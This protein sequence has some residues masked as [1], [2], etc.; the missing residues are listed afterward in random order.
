MAATSV[1]LID[2]L[3]ALAGSGRFATVLCRLSRAR[4]TGL[5]Y[6]E[7]EE[8]GAVLSYRD[9]CPVFIEDLGGGTSLGDSLLEQGTLTPESYATVLEHALSELT[10]SEDAAFA[11]KAV[12]LGVL[13]QLDVDAELQRR[14]RGQMIQAIAWD[15]ARIELDEDPDALSGPEYPQQLGLL[16][17]MAVRTFF[18]EDR[19]AAFLG[20]HRELYLRLLRPRAEVA[21]DLGLDDAERALLE[22][23]DPPSSV[24]SAVDRLGTDLLEAQQLVAM[25]IISENVEHACRPWSAPIET[26]TR[27]RDR[28][29]STP[30]G[31]YVAHG[32]LTEEH[33]GPIV[34]PPPPQPAAPK[35]QVA[36]ADNAA[37]FEAPIATPVRSHADRVRGEQVRIESAHGAPPT[38]QT[39]NTRPPLPPGRV[40]SVR[41]RKPEARPRRLGAALKRLGRELDERRA[42]THQLDAPGN[43]PE[44]AAPARPAAGAA[45][46]PA[47]PVGS[48]QAD[49]ANAT[50]RTAV[51][52]LIRRKRALAGQ[53]ARSSGDVSGAQPKQSSAELMRSARDALRE[54]QYARAQELL[55]RACEAEPNNET[56]KM[57]RLWAGFR[58]GTLQEAEQVA[59]RTIVRDKINDDAIKPFASYAMGHLMLADKK[60]DAAEKFFKKAL[61]LDKNNRDAERH[62]RLIGARRKTGSSH[63]ANNKIFGIEIG[64]KS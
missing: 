8:G 22:A 4:F 53:Q 15:S 11:T 63:E 19:V 2:E 51:K 13:T 16:L 3:S 64:K 41:P 12:E 34:R 45:Y 57:Y 32:A 61:E 50:G 9:G 47:G 37:P 62:V 43:A 10:G 23:L 14:I 42:Q 40:A 7:R 49:G 25:L 5:L 54:Q 31:R 27:A 39:P 26:S 33:L 58:A 36:K 17:Y 48:P 20:E 1:V 30:M 55:V 59:L 29:P 46:A 44:P 6:V 18:D 52:E 24:R 21:D 56:F 28:R 60:E 35:E 38:A